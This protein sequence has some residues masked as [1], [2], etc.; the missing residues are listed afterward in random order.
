[1]SQVFKHWLKPLATND[2]K[3]RRFLVC[4]YFVQVNPPIKPTKDLAPSASTSSTSS[5]NLHRIFTHFPSSII[6]S[7]SSPLPKLTSGCL[8]C[9]ASRLT[10]VPLQHPG[11]RASSD[12]SNP[13]APPVNP[14]LWP[15]GND[16][17]SE[18]C[19][20]LEKR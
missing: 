19:L 13:L 20:E 7:F 4:G 6:E 16:V 9:S 3:G 14:F 5:P 2:C 18:H 12:P 15:K 1:M 10:S 8:A 17:W 11:R